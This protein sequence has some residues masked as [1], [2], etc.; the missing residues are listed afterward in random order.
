MFL[1]ALLW[2]SP[3]LS[4]YNCKLWICSQMWMFS[5]TQEDQEQC[6]RDSTAQCRGQLPFKADLSLCMGKYVPS[7]V[8]DVP[9]TKAASEKQGLPLISLSSVGDLNPSWLWSWVGVRSYCHSQTLLLRC[10]SSQSLAC[11]CATENLLCTD[12][13]PCCRRPSCRTELENEQ[14]LGLLETCPPWDPPQLLET[15][16]LCQKRTHKWKLTH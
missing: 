10:S 12:F 9:V 11:V 16:G 4:H 15:P 3:D 7:D 5:D 13:V 14:L 8:L 6:C 1:K 2:L